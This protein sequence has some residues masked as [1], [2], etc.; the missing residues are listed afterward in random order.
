MH[1]LKK[2]TCFFIVYFRI[3]YDA[4]LKEQPLTTP[5]TEVTTK[6]DPATV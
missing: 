6:K 4:V 5:L 2:L 3:K 1:H